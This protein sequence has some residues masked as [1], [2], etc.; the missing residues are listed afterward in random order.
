MLTMQFDRDDVDGRREAEVGM[1][2]TGM[3][4]VAPVG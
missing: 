3:P 4:V 2:G 1:L